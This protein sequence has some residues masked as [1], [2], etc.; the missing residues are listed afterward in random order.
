MQLDDHTRIGSITKTMTGTVIL[1]LVDEGKL[2]LDQPLSAFRPDIPHADAITIRQ[3]LNMTSGLFNYSDDRALDQA[4]DDHP[5]QPWT[6]EQLV[7]FGLRY[8][9]YFAPGE[10][11]HYSNTNYA[12]LGLIDDNPSWGG[13]AGAVIATL[14]DLHRWAPAPGNGTLLKPATQAARLTWVGIGPQAQNGLGIPAPA[15][16]PT[17]R[18]RFRPRPGA[19]TPGQGRRRRRA[20]GERLDG[21]AQ[22]PT[23]GARGRGW[24]PARRQREPGGGNPPP[25]GL[26]T[27]S[28][29]AGARWPNDARGDQTCY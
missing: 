13:A 24:P 12:L 6:P 15:G 29:A 28:A 21:A 4:L 10:G 20:A 7:Q 17:P 9:P 19:S 22:R 1:R 8:P 5:Q 18:P 26:P 14:D 25:Y 16:Q 11:Y 27:M 23:R 2:G 3:L